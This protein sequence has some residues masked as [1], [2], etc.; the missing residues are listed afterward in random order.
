LDDAVALIEHGR[1][2]GLAEAAG[3]RSAD[4]SLLTDDERDTYLQA[5]EVIQTIEA[6]SRQGNDPLALVEEARV[7]NERLAA[8]VAR[9][10]ST[11]PNFLPERNAS[12]SILGGA[13]QSGEVLMYLI[14]QDAGTLLLAVSERGQ[15]QSTWLTNLTSNDISTLAVHQRS[16]N[17]SQSGFLPAAL[18]LLRHDRGALARALD[19]LL[20]QLGDQLMR[21]VVAM[22]RDSSCQRVVLVP[23][24]YLSVLP[25]HAATYAP[26]DGEPATAPEGRRYACD[27]LA[28]TYAPSGLTLL[29][30]H[31]AAAH[32]RREGPA[33]Q[34]FIAGNPQLTLKDQSWTPQDRGYLRYA[35]WEARTVGEIARQRMRPL[36]VDMVLD[37]QAT[38][39]CVTQRLGEADVAH[40][41]LHATFNYQEPEQ[42]AFLVAFGVKLLLRDLLDARLANL[43]QLRLVTLSACQSALSDFSRQSEE[44]VGLFGALL[45]GGVPG[46]IGTLWSVNDLATAALME[47]FAW[48][49]LVAGDAA[50]L[51]LRGATRNLRGMRDV[52][53]DGSAAEQT[54]KPTSALRRWRE[55]AERDPQAVDG[56]RLLTSEEFEAAEK[57]V[58]RF[59]ANQ[60]A[61]PIAHN[62]PI[63]WAAFVFHGASV[64]L[65]GDEHSA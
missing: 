12:A 7:A 20:P 52:P 19:E 18:G 25:L 51:A 62:H 30:A 36:N 22:A 14:P 13:L 26:L 33:R 29:D 27:D 47:S 39:E 8:V 41:A 21:Y 49:Y 35:E 11:Y 44:A 59:V 45:A 61:R 37:E 1:A 3:R 48:R 64:P 34:I 58:H 28:I 32:Q 4:L 2:R 16:D 5:V 55:L 63:Y 24:G 6:Q 42:S 53:A 43:T 9:L 54:A 65:D 10:R 50:D 46:V 31:E 15:L 60:D 57:A 38:W 56:T 17:D 23:S 40:L